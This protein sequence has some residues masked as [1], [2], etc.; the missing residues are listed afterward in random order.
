MTKCPICDRI[1]VFGG[2]RAGGRR[3]CSRY[4][5]Q[6]GVELDSA[7]LSPEEQGKWF[8]NA[9][10]RCWVCGSSIYSGE[11][12]EGYRVFCCPRCQHRATELKATWT[13]SASGESH[14]RREVPPGFQLMK[15]RSTFQARQNPMKDRA[16]F[17][18]AVSKFA[19]EAKHFRRSV[20]YYH[21]LLYG[22]LLILFFER[23]IDSSQMKFVFL[24]VVCPILF[25]GILVLKARKL[26]SV[27]EAVGLRCPNCRLWLARQI[28]G[29]YTRETGKCMRC[30]TPIYN[31]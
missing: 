19:A 24:V 28:S 27:E 30:G 26:D 5:S 22:W 25:V 14:V 3:Y 18:S 13:P 11:I 23:P 8:K 17:E 15:D 6:R 29:A 2:C 7:N 4:C 1:I 16:E 20:F 31:R 12:R 10:N 21:F 9:G